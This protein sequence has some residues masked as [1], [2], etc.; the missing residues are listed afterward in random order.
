MVREA[1]DAMKNDG[2]ERVL[3]C[4]TSQINSER[5]IDRA[6]SLADELNGELHILHVQQ[7]NSIFNN[8]DT[9][10][11]MHRLCQ[12]GSE[13]GG[14]I[15]FYCDEDVAKCIGGFVSQK[16]IT[17]LVIGQPPVNNIKDIKKLQEAAQKVL[18]CIKEP[19]EIIVIPRED[20]KENVRFNV[21]K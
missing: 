7:G 20:D 6:A 5:L 12:Y 3:V 2:I 18:K 4:I 14:A 1:V 8:S 10:E 19:V 16:G 13:K 9:P 21:N 15:H 11:M 17:R